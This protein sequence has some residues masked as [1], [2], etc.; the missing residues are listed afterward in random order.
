MSAAA[1]TARCLVACPGVWSTMVAFR[2]SRQDAEHSSIY[3][4]NVGSQHAV[5]RHKSPNKV[6]SQSSPKKSRARPFCLRERVAC[7]SRPW[8][9]GIA[10]AQAGACRMRA[11]SHAHALLP[12][13]LRPGQ[14]RPATPAAARVGPMPTPGRIHTTLS[15]ITAGRPMAKACGRRRAAA[16]LPP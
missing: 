4:K 14:Y 2:Q 7:L 3:R 1:M 6:S 12:I 11:C 15:S 8:S 5:P 9:S 16:S 13:A 10:A